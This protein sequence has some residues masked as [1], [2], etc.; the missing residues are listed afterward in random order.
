MP[1]LSGGA[2]LWSVLDLPPMPDAVRHLCHPGSLPEVSAAVSGD[3]LPSVRRL[4]P[5]VR[6]ASTPGAGRWR[7]PHRAITL[8][9]R[10][11]R[12][13]PCSRPRPSFSSSPFVFRFVPDA[14]VLSP[15]RSKGAGDRIE[16]EDENEG[17]GRLTFMGWEGFRCAF[18]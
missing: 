7:S 11:G 6:V 9:T 3:K 4:S 5:H 1:R 12:V 13:A 17:R 16:D 14:F 8:V 18:R 2:D 15:L 10:P